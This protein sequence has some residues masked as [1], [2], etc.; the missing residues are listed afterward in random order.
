MK[1]ACL[2]AAEAHPRQATGNDQHARGFFLILPVLLLAFTPQLAAKKKA[3]IVYDKNVD[4][5]GY[6]T[7]A[8]VPGFPLVDPRMDQYVIHSVDDV[9]RRS[10]LTETK[11]SEAD[12]VV[13][14]NAARDTDLSIGTALDPTFAATGG[15][16]LSGQS[17]WQT[18]STGGVS[19]HVRKGSLNFEILDR[20]ANKTIWSGTAKNT[21]SDKPGDQWSQVQKALDDLFHDYPPTT[22]KGK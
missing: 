1:Q 8:W 14:Y 18:S 6:K 9:L 20:K 19:T 3:D 15:V 2:E 22:T 7:Y 10:G 13:T 16:P 11:V 12:V 17:I 4:F 5:S 21:I